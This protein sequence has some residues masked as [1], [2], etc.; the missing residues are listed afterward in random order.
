[1]SLK[2]SAVGYCYE[3]PLCCLIRMKPWQEKLELA[4]K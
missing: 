3:K 1:M 4:N 2:G